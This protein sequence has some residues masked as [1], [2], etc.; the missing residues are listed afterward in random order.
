M[1]YPSD[2]RGIALPIQELGYE[3][4]PYKKGR[5]SNHHRF[6]ERR[7]YMGSHIA[8]MFRGLE[9]HVQTMWLPEHCSLHQKYE[10]P[11][12]PERKLMIDVLDD[13]AQEHGELHIVREQNTNEI[14]T[15]NVEQWRLLRDGTKAY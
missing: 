4:A 5:T 14:Y 7:K 10:G 8:R 15:I 3:E 2:S 12:I 9:P 6:F 1:R 13:Y 11:K